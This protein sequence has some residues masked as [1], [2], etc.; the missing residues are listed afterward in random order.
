MTSS[1]YFHFALLCSSHANSNSIDVGVTADW[2]EISRWINE[3]GGYID[4]NVGANLTSHNGFNIRGVTVSGKA[5]SSGERLFYVPKKLWLSLDKFPDIK[6]VQL[7]HVPHCGHPF[8]EEHLNLIK[9]AGALARE[10]RKG[11]AS[12]FHVYISRL[13][14]LEDFRSFHPRFMKADVQ[15]DFAGLPLIDIVQELQQFDSELRN[16]FHSWTQAENSPVAGISADEFDLAQTQFRTR[17]FGSGESF[18]SMVPGADLLNTAR[19]IRFNTRWEII[20]DNFLMKADWGGAASGTE[21]Y[22]EYCETCGNDMMMTLWG[23]YLED[24]R[25]PLK[26]QAHCNAKADQNPHKPGKFGSLQQAAEA[27]LDLKG[28]ELARKEDWRAPR[29]RSE[30]S[31]MD[32]GPMRCSLARL[33]FEHCKQEWGYLG[34]RVPEYAFF[35]RSFDYS[36]VADQI[37]RSYIHGV[38][39]ML[40]SSSHRFHKNLRINRQKQKTFH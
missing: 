1:W 9:I 19:S 37:T 21:L 32:Q 33:A 39:P 11:N 30:L 38:H 16:C 2:L 15:E 35:H 22:D 6:N 34:S 17:A 20:G 10:R 36:Q 40:L 29:C 3:N 12:V 24:N 27:M 31:S 23:L 26:T 18:P 14:S 4:P 25:N 7:A 13:P 5:V 8:Q 28:L